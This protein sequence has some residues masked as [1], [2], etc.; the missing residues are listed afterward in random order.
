MIAL[1]ISNHTI[2]LSFITRQTDPTLAE[3][4]VLTADKSGVDFALDRVPD[5]TNSISGTVVNTSN[6]PV[7]DV[8][9]VAYRLKLL[10]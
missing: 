10:R 9:V 4:I 5:Y 6:Q 1:R 8:Y 3:E 2:S 7:M